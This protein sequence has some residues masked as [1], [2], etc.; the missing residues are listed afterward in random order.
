MVEK[1]RS[2]ICIEIPQEIIS[3]IGTVQ[4]HLRSTARGVRWTRPEGIHLTLKFLGDVAVDR[5]ELIAQAVAVAVANT[6]VFTVILDRLG[7]FPNSRR[8]KVIWVGLKDPSNQLAAC[9][10]GIEK[11]L[12]PLGFPA[13]ERR[14]SPHLTLARIKNPNESSDLISQMGR[15]KIDALEFT[16]HEVVIKRS[17]LRPDGAVYTSLRSIGLSLP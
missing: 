4:H 17:D 13:E 12:V 2:F 14:F 6:P 11:V 1:V 16:A 7:F 3:Y 8:P 10:S 15:Q 9:Q 5:I